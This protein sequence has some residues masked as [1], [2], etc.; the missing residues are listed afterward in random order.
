LTDFLRVIAF[1][2]D[3]YFSEMIASGRR[4]IKTSFSSGKTPLIG[5]HSSLASKAG[6]RSTLKGEAQKNVVEAPHID[7][8]PGQ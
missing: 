3:P 7:P 1:K 5:T 2:G 6:V 4:K 8:D